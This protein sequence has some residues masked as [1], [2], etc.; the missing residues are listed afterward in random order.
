MRPHGPTRRL[1][2]YHDLPHPVDYTYIHS[3]LNEIGEKRFPEG[4]GIGPAWGQRAF[5]V[6]GSKTSIEKILSFSLDKVNNRHKRIYRPI[7]EADTEKRQASVKLF[8]AM[9]SLLR[10]VKSGEVKAYHMTIDDKPARIPPNSMHWVKR[11]MAIFHTGY[12]LADRGDGQRDFLEVL[13]SRSDFERWLREYYSAEESASKFTVLS[14]DLVQALRAELCRV[15]AQHGNLRF[16]EERLWQLMKEAL[17]PDIQIQRATF[18]REIFNQL[19]ESA[20]QTVG[21]GLK[22]DRETF[23]KIKGQV[24]LR[25]VQRS[26]QAAV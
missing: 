8:V 22:R 26:L 17:L 18:E 11:W 6:V 16:S 10:A 19:P 7:S 21:A 12:V 4:W 5:K 9:F 13:L 2:R 24:V 25:A 1:L 15:S 23:T 14:D 3:A 20:R